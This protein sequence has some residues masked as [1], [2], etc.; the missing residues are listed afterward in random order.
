MLKISLFALMAC[1]GVAATAC[2]GDDGGGSNSGGSGGATGGSGGTATTGGSGGTAGASGG[3]GGTT[4]ETG[5]GYST[6]EASHHVGKFNAT[7]LDS[8]GKPPAGNVG[9]QVCGLVICKNV[10]TDANGVVST[11][12]KT[13]NIC[14]P[15]VAIDSDM[16]RP[17]FKYGKGIDYVKF[18]LLLEPGA[19]D[20]DVGTQ[21]LFALPPLSTGAEMIPGSDATSGSI[22][23]GIP[24][25]ASV[26][27]STLFDFDT[28]DKLKFR[29]VEIP[30]AQAPAAVDTTL[31][32]EMLVGTTPVEARFCGAK[33]KLTVPNT[34]NW[35]AGTEVEFWLH[36]VDPAE[37][38]APYAGWAKV[39]GGSVSSDG[40]TVSTNDGEGIPELSVIG[41]KK[42]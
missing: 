23:L 38:W 29:A 32:F 39:S 2:G 4:C 36:G 3:S 6:G 31:G 12:D 7:V 35:P 34:P 37:E 16:T 1:L 33:A 25:A 26:E 18:G 41:I 40:T 22:V 24:A 10:D 5:P 42:K 15:G 28:P 11:C 30:I 8:G 9:T 17:A 21:T 13:T 20:Y 19:T 27:T 14:T